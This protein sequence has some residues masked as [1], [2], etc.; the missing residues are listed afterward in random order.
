MHNVSVRCH[1]YMSQ[2]TKFSVPSPAITLKSLSEK[3][4]KLSD[5]CPHTCMLME[6]TAYKTRFNSSCVILYSDIHT[7]QYNTRGW[8]QFCSVTHHVSTK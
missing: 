2:R 6:Q 4:C 8:A 7:P 3:W 1:T 5:K